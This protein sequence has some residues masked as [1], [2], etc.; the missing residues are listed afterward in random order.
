MATYET[1]L[2]KFNGDSRVL[3][4]GLSLD[5]AQAFCEHDDSSSRT[6]MDKRKL[7]SWGNNPN[8]PW[9]VGYRKE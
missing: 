5:E 1:V 4:T 9:F 7:A 8:N 3:D 2:F 6:C